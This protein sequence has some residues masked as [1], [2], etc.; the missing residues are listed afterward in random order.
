MILQIP[1]YTKLYEMNADAHKN[2]FAHPTWLLLRG[3]DKNTQTA[4]IRK[5]KT[6]WHDYGGNK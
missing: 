5:A 2:T 4:D 1:C 6:Y 3:G